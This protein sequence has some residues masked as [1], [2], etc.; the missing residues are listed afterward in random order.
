LKLH[1]AGL[2]SHLELTKELKPKYQLGSFYSY[3]T[4]KKAVVFDEMKSIAEHYILD[5]GAHTLQQ[6]KGNVRFEEYIVKYAEFIK[7]HP[8]IHQ[9]VELDIDNVVGYKTVMKWR[10]YLEAETGKPPIVVW[11]HERGVQYWNEMIK[12]YPYVG[13]PCLSVDKTEPYWNRFLQSAHDEK[14]LVHGFGLSAN[15]KLH[16]YDFDSADS[17]SWASG[18]RYGA[19]YR[20]EDGQIKLYRRDGYKEGCKPDVKLMNRTNME[21]WIKFQNYIYDHKTNQINKSTWW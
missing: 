13:I 6:G 19:R 8:W 17:S 5:S 7:E 2:E 15:K 10:D 1:L 12:S 9:Y 21:E 16:K 11:H 4:P 20:F 3:Q 18:C 14:C